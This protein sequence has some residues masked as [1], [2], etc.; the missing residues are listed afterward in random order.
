MRRSDKCAGRNDRMGS[1][2]IIIGEN[3]CRLNRKTRSGGTSRADI[4]I[5]EE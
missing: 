4:L 1:R 3:E 2:G 5:C